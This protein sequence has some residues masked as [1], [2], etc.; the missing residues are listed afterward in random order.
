[1]LENKK[2]NKIASNAVSYMPDSD[3]LFVRIAP[4]FHYYG[5]EISDNFFVIR[6]DNDDTV[7]GFEV[8][9]YSRWDVRK[10][11][12]LFKDE[13]FEVEGLPAREHKE[14]LIHV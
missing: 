11:Q 13:G 4:F 9:D 12:A 8:L 1:M 3:I 6:R 2:D 10:I 14:A 5:D 7:L